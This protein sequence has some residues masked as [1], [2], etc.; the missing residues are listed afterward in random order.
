MEVRKVLIHGTYENSAS[1]ETL[2]VINPST[3]DIISLIPICEK[4]DVDKAVES[5]LIGFRTWKNTTAEQRAKIIHAAAELMRQNK[6][7]LAKEISLEMGKPIKAALE[8]VNSSADVIDFFAEE[9]LRIKGDIYQRNY[10]N[11]QIQVTKEPVGVVAGITS[12]NYPIALISWKL[13]AALACGCSFISKPNEHSSSSAMILGQLFLNAGLPVGVFNVISGNG[14]TG[15]LLVEHPDVAKVS[16]TG[17]NEV[18]KKVA[19][20]AAKSC[21]RISLE[22]G[23]QSA[24]IVMDGIVSEEIIDDFVAQAFRNSGQNCYRINRAYI[25]SEIYDEFINV[26][27]DRVSKLKV[28]AADN[29]DTDLGPLYRKGILNRAITHIRDADEK[30][31]KLIYGGNQ[32]K[33]NPGT[34]YVEPTIFAETNHSMLIMTDESFSPVLSIMKIESISEAINYVNDSIYGL[35]SFVYTHDAGLGLQVARQL[36]TGVVWV[37]KIHRAYDFAPF[38]GC[39]QSGYG[40]EKSNYG[41]NEYLELKTVYLSLP[42]IN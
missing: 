26:L 4:A 40:R 8:E 25:H 33:S 15:D 41:L 13:G 38:G 17:S 28:G 9:G 3:G 21:K 14:I 5:S 22:L 1:S 19:E 32:I 29:P 36:E 16:F 30:G 27:L 2:E 20:S 12:A 24:A 42:E 39:K 37:N 34:Y 31:A 6:E 23:G 7:Q 11:E 35:A 10:A 18:G